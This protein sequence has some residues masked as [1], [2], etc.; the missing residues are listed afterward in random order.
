MTF[1]HGYALNPGDSLEDLDMGHGSLLSLKVTGQ[2]SLG[3][4]TVLEGI[5]HS[6]GPPLH[7]HDAEDEVV[8]VLDGQLE[9]QVGEERGALSKGGVLWFPRHVPHAVANLADEPCRFL[10]LVTPSG[11]EDFFRHQRDYLATLP[12]GSAPD[13]LALAGVSGAEQRRVVGP[14][15]TP[16][17]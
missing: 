5:V 6:G 16:R 7:V 4:V 12:P 14:P 15:L 9:Y 1:N 2:Q 10:T 3:L 8:I 11:I 13:P 17:A